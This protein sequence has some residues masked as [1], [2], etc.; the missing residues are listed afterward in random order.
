M[1]NYLSKSH[2]LAFMAQ[3]KFIV[4]IILAL[5]VFAPDNGFSQ[6]TFTQTTD[7]DFSA[8]YLD[9]VVVA[10]N[11]VYLAYK[12]TDINNWITA[13]DLPQTLTGHKVTRWKNY[14][15]LSGGFN[16]TNYSDAVYR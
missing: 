11:N 12:A 6:V 8:G 15:Y 2:R 13:N 10:S 9:N 4:I 7:A 14:V 16:G 5:L 3:I 1:K